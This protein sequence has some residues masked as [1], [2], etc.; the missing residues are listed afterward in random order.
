MKVALRIIIGLGFYLIKIWPTVSILLNNSTLVAKNFII[1]T[2]DSL[3]FQEIIVNKFLCLQKCSIDPYC[4]YTQYEVNTCSLYSEDAMNKLVSSNDKIIYQKSNYEFQEK[5]IM[6]SNIQSDLSISC[7]NSSYFSSIK[8][9]S[10]LPCKTGFIK[11]SELPFNCYHYEKGLRNYV[12]S[13]SYCKS[14]GGV[15]FTPQTQNER[16]FLTQRF[17]DEFP[18]LFRFISVNVNSSITRVEEKF[19]W[20]DGSDVVGFSKGEPNNLFGSKSYLREGC[21]EIRFNAYF[22]D[23]PCSNSYLLTI[24]QQE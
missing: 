5:I 11:Y 4:L 8:T 16:Y 15:L 3:I 1:T 23:I 6:E 12:D 17:S 22:Y 18:I 9:N 20:P 24:C 13:K 10:C 7:L 14:S 2:N 21:L 19:K